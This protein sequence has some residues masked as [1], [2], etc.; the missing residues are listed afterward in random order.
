MPKFT[1]LYGQNNMAYQ[2]STEDAADCLRYKHMRRHPQ[3]SRGANREVNI[4]GASRVNINTKSAKE[5]K[6]G[7][8]ITVAEAKK[9][10]QNGRYETVE[11]LFA[12]IEGVDWLAK[13]DLFYFGDE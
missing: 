4:K 7:L 9:V 12:V 2:V 6:D 11:D 5:L 1:T 3:G 10:M 8:G 13:Q